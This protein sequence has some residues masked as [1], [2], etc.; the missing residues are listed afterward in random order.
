VVRE[1]SDVFT[2]SQGAT[3]FEGE[4]YGL[5]TRVFINARGLPTYEAKELGLNQMKADEFHPDESII[6][7][8]NEINEYFRV[9]KKAM[10]LTIS[11]IGNRTKHIG[12]GMLRLPSGKMSSR[13]GDVIS[14]ESLFDEIAKQIEDSGIITHETEALTIAAI[15]YSIL[16]QGIGSDII[17]DFK[18]S[19]AL[20]GD[21]G[22]SLQ[23]ARARLMS[24]IEKVGQ[25]SD[26]VQKLSDPQER[27]LMRHLLDFPYAIDRASTEYSPNIL[28]LYLRELAEHTNRYYEQTRILDDE[29]VSRKGAR[30]LLISVVARVLAHGLLLLGIS[31]PDRL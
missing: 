28:A 25:A 21:S 22:P 27:I 12:H 19:I 4:K 26:A 15:R 2:Q 1:H 5:H 16:K 23:Y 30:I 6:V 9:L 17:F 18:E 29:D 14:A 13:T 3:I 31:S 11:E 24:I 8:G 10:E 20:T 7:T